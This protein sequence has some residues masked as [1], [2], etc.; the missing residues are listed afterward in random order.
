[1]STGTPPHN[2]TNASIPPEALKAA[3]ELWAQAGETHYIPLRGSSMLPLLQDGDHVLVS[4]NRDEIQFGDIVVFQRVDGLVAHRVLRVDTSGDRRTL[5]TKGDN[6]LGLDPKMNEE[7][8]VGKVLLVRRGDRK[9]NVDTPVWRASGKLI[10]A[11]MLAQS[12]LYHKAGSDDNRRLAIELAGIS[13]MLSRGILWLG[14]IL[15][16]TCQALFGHWQLDSDITPS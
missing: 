6:A 13:T 11:I 2:S 16:F 10:A 4:H 8:L 12:W 7:E 1:M 9:M 5:R 3:L 15:I 14:A